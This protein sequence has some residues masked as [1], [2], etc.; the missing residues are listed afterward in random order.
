MTWRRRFVLAIRTA[1]G[2]VLHAT[3]RLC[4]RQL[5]M[6][7]PWPVRRQTMSKGAWTPRGDLGQDTRATAGPTGLSPQLQESEPVTPD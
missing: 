2:T 6:W 7:A 3:Q 1:I 5:M 4:E